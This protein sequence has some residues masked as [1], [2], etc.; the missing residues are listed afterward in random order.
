MRMAAPYVATFA[1]GTSMRV[2][3]A[4]ARAELGWRLQYRTYRD[5]LAAV[6]AA[7]RANLRSVSN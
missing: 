2:S 6:S 5:G 3:N 7:R 1:V 4:K